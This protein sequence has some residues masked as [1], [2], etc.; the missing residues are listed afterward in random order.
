MIRPEIR[1]AL[2]GTLAIAFVFGI[3]QINMGNFGKNGTSG[4]Q[5][6]ATTPTQPVQQTAE[7]R[8][9]NAE[10]AVLKKA[11][12][13]RIKINEASNL[14][15]IAQ[16]QL[17]EIAV[18]AGLP[19]GSNKPEQKERLKNALKM[20]KE[21]MLEL[22]KTD[23]GAF[24]ALTLSKK[25]RDQIPPE[26]Q[27]EVE[28]EVKVSGTLEVLHVDDFD[29]PA[30]SEYRYTLRKQ[31]GEKNRLYSDTPLLASPGTILTASGYVLGGSL[32]VTVT[33][34]TQPNFL[35]SPP[36]SLGDQKTI[37]FL[38]NFQNNIPPPFSNTTAY[39]LIFNGQFQKFI[40]D[41][42]YNK[43]GFT[44]NVYGWIPVAKLIK[45]YALACQQADLSTPEIQDYI[46]NNNIDLGQYLRVFFV[47]NSKYL[48]GGCSSV[49]TWTFPNLIY[50]KT[51]D[52]SVMWV[53]SV[54]YFNV[55][56]T[57]TS[58]LANNN[59]DHLLVHEAGHSLGLQHANWLD[60]GGESYKPS[61][62]G[63][64][65]IEYGNPF[66]VMG[67]GNGH[68][69]AFYKETLGWLDDSSI[70]KIEQSGSYSLKPLEGSGLG[71][72]GAKIHLLGT[73]KYPYYLEYRKPL[74]FDGWLSLPQFI[75]NT[76][77]LIINKLSYYGTGSLSLGESRLLDMS[78]SVTDS[79]ESRKEAAL[80]SGKVFSDP[81]TGIIIGPVNFTSTSD[82]SFN[83]QINQIPCVRSQPEITE[84]YSQPMYT[85]GFYSSING[86]MSLSFKNNDSASC[87]DSKFKLANINSQFSYTIDPIS[88]ETSLIQP[89]SEMVGKM[90][91][92]FEAPP[93][94]LPGVYPVK[95]DLVNIQSGQILSISKNLTVK[96][97]P[98]LISCNGIQKG[99]FIEWTATAGGSTPPYYFLWSGAEG[100]TG[101]TATTITSYTTSGLKTATVDVF[102]NNERQTASCSVSFVMP[103]VTSPPAGK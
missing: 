52:L 28:A 10:E 32:V 46:R 18:A 98:L 81:D 66:D 94:S 78:P 7:Q 53:G 2:F 4:Q 62:L 101:T 16:G 55:P 54:Q 24:L 22:A 27:S 85:P 90:R 71:Y 31:N 39:D 68:Y 20:R 13:R 77:G 15:A 12:D 70:Q 72:K 30:N 51:Y 69:N 42:S 38:V 34:P 40:K 11:E 95:F 14:S 59:F 79:Y 92:D 88:N 63:C 65:N 49:G 41:T 25:E 19:G 61:G 8:K 73:A 96:T 45:D 60:C 35:P 100:V 48:N 80:V 87:G 84:F 26:L 37:V 21:A 86:F 82:I 93:Q 97:R 9:K 67:S 36:K 99:S 103:T 75:S 64:T 44:G 89:K 57:S 76:N 29:N 91:L 74:G 17:S 5:A 33:E 43:A 23:P 3:A 102:A 58:S 56:P 47:L 83:I 1:V 50:G 6:A